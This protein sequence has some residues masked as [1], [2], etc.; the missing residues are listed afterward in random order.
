VASVPI[1]T[2]GNADLA[3]NGFAGDS[4]ARVRRTD[5]FVPPAGKG[6]EMLS[7]SREQK[8]DKLIELLRAKG[9]VQ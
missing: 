3:M 7:G 5:Y 9:G 1:P 4:A 2:L 8:I 6:A